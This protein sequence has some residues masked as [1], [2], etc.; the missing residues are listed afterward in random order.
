MFI[1]LYQEVC[2]STFE[3]SLFGIGRQEIQME[4][5]FEGCKTDVQLTFWV[6]REDRL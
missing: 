2:Q 5:N 1:T 6:L 3:K 4:Q